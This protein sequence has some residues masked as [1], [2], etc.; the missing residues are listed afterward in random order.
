MKKTTLTLLLMILPACGSAPINA[1]KGTPPTGIDASID[2]GV[3]VQPNAGV[4]VGVDEP[5]G[6]GVPRCGAGRIAATT[7][8]PMVGDWRCQETDP[9][10]TQVTV[11]PCT[12]V[13][14]KRTFVTS[15]DLCPKTLP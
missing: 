12:I 8:C 13:E 11:L 5:L 15:C 14:W 1:N 4:D 6:S 10:Q 2:V 3:D 7:E 9:T